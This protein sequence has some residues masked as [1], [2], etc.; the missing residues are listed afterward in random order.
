MYDWPSKYVCQQPRKYCVWT[1]IWGQLF[2][3][4]KRQDLE[5]HQSLVPVCGS[6]N[7]QRCL[8]NF[9]HCHNSKG[10]CAAL[11]QINYNSNCTNVRDCTC[12]WP[13]L[14]PFLVHQHQA[15]LRTTVTIAITITAPTKD[16]KK[17]NVYHNW[18]TDLG[19]PGVFCGFLVRFP[20]LLSCLLSQYACLYASHHVHIPGKIIR[21][22]S[23]E[24]L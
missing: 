23:M 11:T 19:K 4:A 21:G 16:D 14:L 20:A 3:S 18:V 12:V 6:S 10:Y 15:E 8:V 22:N 17:K 1:G 7:C 5:M 24:I 13:W 9:N 2:F